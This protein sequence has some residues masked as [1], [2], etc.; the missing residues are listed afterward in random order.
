M[1]CCMGVS[2]LRFRPDQLG[3]RS[4][5]G[6]R[7]TGRHGDTRRKADEESQKNDGAN[8]EGM[9]TRSVFLG[10]CWRTH[11]HLFDSVGPSG[12]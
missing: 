1:N 3:R 6:A 7:D 11:D 5:N 12:V 4:T 8:D 2:R 10:T 9:A